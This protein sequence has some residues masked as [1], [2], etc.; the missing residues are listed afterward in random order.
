MSLGSK[1]NTSR[2]NKNGSLEARKS[3]AIRNSDPSLRKSTDAG[4]RGLP[5]MS[6]AFPVDSSAA[7][8]APRQGF[9]VDMSQSLASKYPRQSFT[10]FLV[11]NFQA[12]CDMHT[13]PQPEPREIIE[14]SVTKVNAQSFS[15]EAIF[16]QY[17]SPRVNKRLTKFC[18]Q[19]T[20]ISQCMIDGQPGLEPS[21]R[22]LYV[23]LNEQGLF[24]PNVT[25]AVVTH[26]DWYLQQLLPKSLGSTNI[27]LPEYFRRWIDISKSYYSRIGLDP[28]DEIDPLV[29]MLKMFGLQ[30]EGPRHSGIYVC[31]NII[32]VMKSLAAENQC[33][34]YI[35]SP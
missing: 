33:V 17:V 25:F 30:F 28:T 10:Y 27:V 12:T 26:G 16:H 8:T 3:V 7:K 35:N 14:F 34:F 31:Y 22:K 1:D 18:T 20:G 4:N 11:V 6:V 21:L 9:G 32:Q 13:K 15:V 29:G 19:L 2:T 23:W 24:K 5:R